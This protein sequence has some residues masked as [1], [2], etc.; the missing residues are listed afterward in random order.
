MVRLGLAPLCGAHH[1]VM[2]APEPFAKDFS[3]PMSIPEEGIDA[4][5][6]VM[7]SG[8]LFRYC[9]TESQVSAAEREFSDM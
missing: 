3:K 5:V 8:R 6:D 4:A 2:Q 7:R 9:A 1:P